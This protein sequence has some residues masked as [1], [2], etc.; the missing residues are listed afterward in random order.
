MTES[1][2]SS[3]RK[4]Y[5]SASRASKEVG[6]SSDYIGQLCRAKK[7]PGKLIGRTWYVDLAYLTEHKNNQRFRKVSGST[8][9]QPETEL[10]VGEINE[11]PMPKMAENLAITYEKDIES[12]LPELVKRSHLSKSRLNIK[13]ITAFSLAFIISINIWVFIM[14]QIEPVIVTKLEQQIENIKDLSGDYLNAFYV[15]LTNNEYMA[16]V[17]ISSDV[18][19]FLEN[20]VIGFRNF[21]K[22]VLNKLFSA[23]DEFGITKI[24]QLPKTDENIT[25]IN[26]TAVTNSTS[27]LNLESVRSELKTELENYVRVQISSLS[28]P[29]IIYSSTP[30]LDNSRLELFKNNEIIPVTYNIVTRQSSSDSSH[31]SSIISNLINDGNFIKATFGTICFSSDTCRTTWP[32]GCNDSGDSFAWTPTSW[33]VSTSTILSFDAGFISN[34]ASSTIAG[35]LLITGNST[36]T[37]ATTTNLY[38]SNL[39]T[40]AGLTDCTGASAKL[41]WS[42]GSFSCG[43]DSGGS[44]GGTWSTTTSQVTGQFAN[45]PNEA[46]DVVI[47][48]SNSSTTAEFYFDPNTTFAKI[49]GQ[50]LV[51]SSSTLQNFTFINATGTSATTTNLAVSSV[52]SSLLKTSPS[53]SLIAAIAGTDYVAGSSF[54]SFPWTPTSWGVSTSTTLGFLQGFLSTAS[55]TFTSDR[56]LSS[57]ATG[58]LGIGTGGLIYSGATTT[59]GTGLSYS[60]NAFNVNTS[61]NIATLSNLTSDGFIRTS[62]GTGALSIDTSTYLTTVDMSTNTKLACTWPI[63]LTGDTLSFNGLSTTTP[64][65]TGRVP[66]V[67]GV[68]TFSDVATSSLVQSTRI[69]IANSTTAYVLGD[70]PTFTIDQSFSPTWTCAHIFNSI[71]RNT[72]TQAT[73]TNLF[74]SITSGNSLAIGSTA[75]TTINSSGDLLVMGS[76]TLQNF[77]FNRATGTSATTTNFYSTTA[78]STNLFTAS[79]SGAGLATNCNGVSNALIWSTTGLFGCNSIIG[80][81]G[82]P[83]AWTPT[84]WGVSTSTILGFDAGFISNSASST[85]AGN[86]LITCNSTTTNATTTNLFSTTASSTNLY[87][88]LLTVGGTGLIVDS[89]KRV[90]IGTTGPGAKLHS[91]ATTEQLRLGYDNDNYIS[92]TADSS[93]N[94]NITGISGIICSSLDNCPDVNFTTGDVSITNRLKLGSGAVFPSAITDTKLTVDGSVVI[95]NTYSAGNAAPSNGL[96]VEGNVGIGTSTPSA[97]LS[98]AGISGGTDPLFTVS[99]SSAAFATTTVFHIDS[100]GNIGIGT[101]SPYTKLSIEAGLN[102]YLAHIKNTNINTSAGGLFIETADANTENALRVD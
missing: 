95:G 9:K 102:T 91:L 20:I 16:T 24:T 14:G 96:I 87:S 51:T 82:D 41:I 42:G 90:G 25:S 21:R 53:G 3:D 38:V 75:T 43:T 28:S 74:S 46:T 65:T 99:S 54:F 22:I 61:Q 80:G 78:S 6:Y 48:G 70:Q 84:S 49:G 57:L 1:L 47:I 34:S 7:I 19:R 60:G 4:E 97:K 79:F 50:L 73:S 15:D 32:N 11:I 98:V 76:T 59:A 2:F 71:T 56:C 85:I 88:S 58:G 62:G 93:A 10:L 86:L 8:Q 52:T 29:V 83:F 35:N 67:S 40:G 81:S 33:G 63:V 100:N 68:N 44:G 77:T 101:T 17:F 66:Y 23:P 36:T 18:G 69:N 37:N 13:K 89:N 72:S 55:S 5:I 27:S 30:T 12:R 31:W 39:F 45:Y 64:L 94:L 92:F 26:T